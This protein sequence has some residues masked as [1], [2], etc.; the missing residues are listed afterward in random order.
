MVAPTKIIARA[1]YGSTPVMFSTV[2]SVPL[3]WVTFFASCLHVSLSP[4][5]LSLSRQML[6]C[7]TLLYH[8][9][10]AVFVNH[11][12]PFCMEDKVQLTDILLQ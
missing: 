8:P 2:L 1:H 11:W 6:V 3:R 12:A 7:S 5:W 10:T 4:V 9:V